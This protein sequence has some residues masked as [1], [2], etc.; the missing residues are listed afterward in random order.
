MV[1]GSSSIN[2]MIFERGGAH[3]YDEWRNVNNPGWGFDD[4][5]PHFKMIEDRQDGDPEWRGAGGLL[6]VSDGGYRD[7]LSCAFMDA[8]VE[9]G[10]LE[11]SDY[12]GAWFG[13]GG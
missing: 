12:N 1:G 6:T 4:L 5:L 11:Y 8:C 7:P 13:G 2:G 3:R 10:T 9:G